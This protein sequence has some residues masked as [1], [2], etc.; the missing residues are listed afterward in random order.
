MPKR[1]DAILVGGGHNSLVAAAYL[2]KA[3]RKT[4]VL[5]KR[6]RVGGLASNASVAPGVEAPAVLHTI[7]RLRRSVIADLGLRKR[8]LDVLRP[9]VRV[10]APQPEG[11]PLMLWSDAARTASE[12]RARSSHD[13]DAYEEFDRHVRSIASF[14]AYLQ[15]ATPPDLKSPSLSDAITGMRLGQNFRRLGAKV[16]REATRVLPMAVG[17]FVAE[18][19]ET[20]AMRGALAARAVQLAAM[21]PWS[22]GTTSVLLMD[23]AGNDGGAAGQTAYARGGPASL[24][25]ALEDAATSFK[26]EVRTGAEVVG[27]I[28]EDGRVRG[29]FLEGGE[30]IRARAVVSGLDPKRT[31]L[32]L[33]DPVELGPSLVWRARNIRTPGVVA[34]VNL[35]LSALP[36]FSGVTDDEA[37]AGRIVIAPSID[38]LEHAFDASKYGR[39]S[40]E[41]YLEATIPSVMDP[42]LAP[43]RQHVMSVLLQYAPYCLRDGDWSSERDGL[44]DVALKTL[45]RYA[46]GISDLVTARKVLT[47][48]DLER[49]YGVTGGHPL[50]GEPALDQFFAWRPLLGHARYRLGLPGLYLCGPGAHPGGGITGGPGANAAREV[51]S[52]LKKRAGK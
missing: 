36:R 16:G 52:D 51:L 40:E 43:A 21:G 24:S 27:T 18:S 26:A 12:L 30:E 1:W 14:L 47:P 11:A 5:E 15:V 6:D 31:L 42:S 45:E 23:S 22:A 3:G 38:Y 2:A 8:G 46:P 39:V 10:L 33:V 13:A 44:G 19:F 9:D 7:G 29:V 48:V 20:D 37:L 41:P 17:D 25:R 50:H 28:V 4:L 34:K 49:E 35:A 32:S